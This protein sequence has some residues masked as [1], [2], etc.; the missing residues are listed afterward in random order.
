MLFTTCRNLYRQ[1]VTRSRRQPARNPLARPCLEG[2]ENR[3]LLSITLVPNVYGSVNIAITGDN[4]DDRVTAEVDTRGTSSPYDDRVVVTRTFGAG[5]IEGRTVPLWFSPASHGRYI[6]ALSFQAG[7]GYNIFDNQT[8]V[9][10]RA[11]GGS[12]RDDFYGGS[13]EDWFYGNGGHDFLF[14]RG[15]DDVLEGGA[16]NDWLSGGD[17]HDQLRGGLGADR[18]YGGAGND[19]LRDWTVS[20]GV[21]TEGG[22]D[23]MYG[24]DGNDNLQGGSG[25]DS[26]SGGAGNDVLDGGADGYADVLNGGSGADKFKAEWYWQSVGGGFAV[27]KNRDQPQDFGSGDLIVSPPLFG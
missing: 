11:Y 13:N 3:N 1:L 16:G 22:N 12:G 17:G 4:G 26:L 14:G 9:I 7:D 15:G 24:G 5:L 23:S 6:G 25:V 27:K 21:V 8:D 10:T 19:S 2:L 18:L 20:F